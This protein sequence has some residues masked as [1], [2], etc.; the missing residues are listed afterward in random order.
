MILA[1]APAQAMGRYSG[2]QTSAYAGGGGCHRGLRSLRYQADP[3]SAATP[4]IA[5]VAATA[6]AVAIV[7][8]MAVV[9]PGS[10]LAEPGRVITTQP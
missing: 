8:F 10:R 9:C 7:V 6:P 5:A 3:G 2:L 1:R 4:P